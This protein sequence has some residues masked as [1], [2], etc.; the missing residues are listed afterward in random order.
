MPARIELGLD[1]SSHFQ[2]EHRE[3]LAAMPPEP[4][5]EYPGS[6]AGLPV[7]GVTP[8]GAVLV[9]LDGRQANHPSGITFGIFCSRFW[10]RDAKIAEQIRSS[11]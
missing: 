1:L 11:A 3:A 7:L 9:Q 4:G 10:G 6:L 8:P 2:R 5:N